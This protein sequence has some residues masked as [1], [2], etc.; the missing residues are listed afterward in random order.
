MP[1]LVSSFTFADA[2]V[3]SEEEFQRA[4]ARALA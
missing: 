1:I 4:R 3:I 2:G